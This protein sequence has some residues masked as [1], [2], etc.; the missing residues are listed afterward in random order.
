MGFCSFI[1]RADT[2]HCRHIAPYYGF[3]PG[4]APS[5]PAAPGQ[6]RIRAQSSNVGAREQNVRCI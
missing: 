3:A 1:P 6:A 2:A 5:L 4:A